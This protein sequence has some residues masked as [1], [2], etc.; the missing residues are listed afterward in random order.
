MSWKSARPWS[1]R[2]RLALVFVA[3][4]LAT[5]TVALGFL[6]F[7][8]LHEISARND[9]LLAGRLQDVAA[10]LA[11][12]PDEPAALTEEVLEETPASMGSPILLRVERDGRT[13]AESW[14]MAQLLPAASWR[15]GQA[16]WAGKR[17]FLIGEQRFGPY[18]IQGALDI[19]GDDRMA[20]TFRRN[21]VYA[22]LLVAAGCTLLG[23]WAAHLGL[24][25]LRTIAE[26]AQGINAQRLRQRLEPEAMPGELRELVL[27]LNAMLDRLDHAFERLH[28]FS[29]DLA[30][31]LRTPLNNLMGEAE[32]ILAR[33]RP[34]EDYRQVLESSLEE[35]RRLTRLISRMLFLARVED[36]AAVAERAPV[37]A[38]RLLA[39]VLAFFEAVAEEGGVALAGEASG[40]LTG[41]ADLLRQAL[42]NLVANA[43]AATPAGGTVRVRVG[44]EGGLAVLEVKDTGRGID[45]RELPR[46]FDRFYRTA[47]PNG[48]GSGLGLAIVQSIA[49]LHGGGVAVSSDPGAGTTV[50]IHFPEP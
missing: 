22:L 34:A 10:V 38:G 21:L 5:L 43:L 32:V 14:G 20:R 15:G 33:D 40:I 19:S 36:P 39:Q 12:H 13:L 16:T 37:D 35:F 47:G 29:A 2:L 17:H 28:R 27:A 26:T 25:P 48:P 8:L 24:K 4:S 3:G 6:Q 42:A 41:D 1:L 30:H 31:E 50:R 45:S 23:A 7:G 44:V 49:Q 18:R 9:K 46:L 11:N